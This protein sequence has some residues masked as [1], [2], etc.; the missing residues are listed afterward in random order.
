MSWL[1]SRKADRFREAEL[2]RALGLNCIAP[3]PCLCDLCF[4]DVPR[5]EPVKAPVVFL[6]LMKKAAYFAMDM[7]GPNCQCVTCR[8]KYLPDMWKPSDG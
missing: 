6:P 1:S 3:M 7:H 5:A 8:P 4:S 2:I